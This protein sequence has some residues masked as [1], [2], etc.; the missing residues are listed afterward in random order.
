MPTAFRTALNPSAGGSTNPYF[1]SVSLLLHM[2]GTN[3]STVFADSS[4]NNL[5]VTANGS[6]QIGTSN[7][8]WGTGSGVF[9]GSGYIVASNSLLNISTGNFTIEAWLY[10]NSVAAGQQPL[11]IY[12]NTSVSFAIYT[13]SSGK[14]NYYLSSN[15]ASWNIAS[16]VQIGSIATSQWYHIA[17]VRNS[18]VF[19][20]YLGGVSGTQTTSS[21]SLNSQQQFVAG[22]SPNFSTGWFNG[23]IDDVRITKGVALYT[24]NFTPP[25]AAFPN[26]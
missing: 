14:V 24:S 5:T 10:F 22:V 12:S 6:A 8:K 16:G 15:G 11:S 21:S 4:S 17:L 1:S 3:A 20:P 9:N 25:T 18:N 19:T 2:D 26:S 13:T 7:P 23:Y